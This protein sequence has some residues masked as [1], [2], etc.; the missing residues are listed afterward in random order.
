[1]KPQRL[2][3][4]YYSAPQDLVESL[5]RIEGNR[6]LRK[7][8]WIWLK[9]VAAVFVIFMAGIL[10]KHWSSTSGDEILAEEVVSSH[11]RSMMA[12]H[13]IDVASS[14]RHTVKPWFNGKLDFSPKVIDLSPD[15]FPLSGGRLDYVSSRPV[16][17]LIY[18][19]NQHIINVLTW[20]TSEGSTK[21]VFSS[22]QG[23]SL[24][25]WKTA[26]MQYWVISDL[27]ANDLKTFS[28]LI[29]ERQ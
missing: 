21:M 18:K 29:I 11:V 6:P 25:H 16:A 20:P 17:A 28:E 10:G 13:L 2:D 15:G 5:S 23:Y 24:F 26:G 12:G 22:R 19:R 9:A 14:D 3:S 1:M 7:P 27:N 8:S 4:L